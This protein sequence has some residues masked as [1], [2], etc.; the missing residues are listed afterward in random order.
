MVNPTPPD[1]IPGPQGAD[2]DQEAGPGKLETVVKS[3][4][5]GLS[6]LGEALS[7]GGFPEEVAG[8]I[9]AIRSQFQGLISKLMGEGEASQGP[10]RARAMPNAGGGVP[11]GPQGV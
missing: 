10:A 5:T 8:E 1:Q 6:L 2:P 4:D 9:G 11:A 3:V 7:Q